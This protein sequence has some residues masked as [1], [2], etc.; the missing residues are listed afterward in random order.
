MPTTARR[1]YVG[2]GQAGDAGYC[3]PAA[4]AM[5]LPVIVPCQS[6]RLAP[7]RSDEDAPTRLRSPNLHVVLAAVSKIMRGMS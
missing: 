5:N 6:A 2:V 4:D 1:G 7:D 3:G